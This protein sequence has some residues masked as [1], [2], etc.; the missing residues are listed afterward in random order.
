MIYTEV[1]I[2][3]G[4]PSGSACAWE[5][6]KRGIDC[7]ILDKE[8]FPRTKLCAGWITPEVLETL[9][10][11]VKDYPYGIIHFDHLNFS[12]FGKKIKIGTS[13]YSIR[14]FEFDKWMLDRSKAKFIKHQVKQI[15]KTSDELYTI[16]D[17][18]TCRYLIGAGGT[19]CPVYKKIFQNLNPRAKEDLIVAQEE[20]FKYNYH[21]DRC[22]L[23]F[24][25][26]K[27]P[28]YSWYVPKMDGYLN[29]GVGGTQN[30]LKKRTD[31]IKNQ[32]K[33]FTNQ[34]IDKSLVSNYSFKPKGHSYY[35]RRGVHQTRFENAFII[36]DAA[37]LATVDMGEGIGPAIDSGILAARSIAT[38][39]G[40]SVKSIGKYSIWGILKSKKRKNPI[41]GNA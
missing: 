31:T 21:D 20:E 11:T 6:N 22:Y 2:T 40:Y 24:F 26:N 13:Q 35:L 3:G 10:I 30:G 14:R 15:N 5:L 27:L 23:W 41:S 39:S 33:F 4:G 34:L 36:G 16:D 38:Q 25:E 37:G 19:H 7:L 29:I 12:F 32:W 8:S 28:G 17:K 9:E 1:I 18:Y